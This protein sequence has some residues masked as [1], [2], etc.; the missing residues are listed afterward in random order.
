MTRNKVSL[1]YKVFEKYAEDLLKFKDDLRDV[2]NQ[3]LQNSHDM[4]T[5]DLDRA[6]KKHNKTG[7][8]SRSIL[9]HST[10]QWEGT[11]ATIDVGFDI[12]NGGLASIYLMYGT[13]RHPPGHPG[14]Q[15]DKELYD[16]IYGAKF[17]RKRRE[18]TELTLQRA[19]KRRLG[20]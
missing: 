2:A 13:P 20:G 11:I 17:K 4:V 1:D 10:V 7:R 19:I 14:T 16:A 18:M 8:T 12:A 5:A 9:R 6:M 3:V 15:A